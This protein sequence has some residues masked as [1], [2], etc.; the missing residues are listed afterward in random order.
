M[1]R[2]KNLF[3]ITFLCILSVVSLSLVA[4]TDNSNGTNK[5]EKP[6]TSANQLRY[7]ENYSGKGYGVGVVDGSDVVGD[8]VIPD[9]YNGKPILEISVDAFRNRENLTSITIPSTV[10]SIPYQGFDNCANLKKVTATG[11]EFVNWWG[12]RNCPKLETVEMPKLKSVG[13]FGFMNCNALTNINL[14]SLEKVTE[15]GFHN[16]NALNNI[17]LTTKLQSIGKYAFYSCNSL[18]EVNF[19]GT[20]A[21]WERVSKGKDYFKS[22]VKI[23]FN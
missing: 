21:Q 13:D 11:V 1:K 19:K 23:N 12:F 15:N 5:N 10:T 8:L 18:T 6:V 2:L 22:T 17:T 9:T 20:K 4:C 7:Y 3:L 16:C 14:E